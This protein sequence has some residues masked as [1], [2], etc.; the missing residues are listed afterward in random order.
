MPTKFVLLAFIALCMSGCNSA[1]TKNDVAKKDLIQQYDSFYKATIGEIF[2]PEKV[3]KWMT[4]DTEFGKTKIKGVN[5]YRRYW[6]SSLDVTEMKRRTK[7]IASN[8][9]Y[10]LGGKLNDRWCRSPEDKPLFFIA[11]GDMRFFGPSNIAGYCQPDHIFALVVSTSEGAAPEDWNNRAANTYHYIPLSDVLQQEKQSNQ[12]KERELVNRRI[13]AETNGTMV[14]ARGVGRRACKE[15]GIWT[16][17]G[18]VNKIENERIQVLV[19]IKS[20]NGVRDRNFTSTV[21]VD[22]A[23][24][25]FPCDTVDELNLHK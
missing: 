17:S 6:C 7:N 12:Y 11:T 2:D 10:E 4:F 22:A 13:L 19:D 18:I 16:Y 3:K 15:S 20:S 14:L 9:C 24:K 21:A 23:S 8:Y 1:P 5:E 25:W